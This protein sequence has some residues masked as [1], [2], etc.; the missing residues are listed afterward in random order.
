MS[1]QS[2]N[3]FT[4][5]A[6]ASSSKKTTGAAI[7]D[8]KF[9][10]S[11]V[12]A[13]RT[14]PGPLSSPTWTIKKPS[15]FISSSSGATSGTC[16]S[17]PQT[18]TAS[19]ICQAQQPTANALPRQMIHC[20]PLGSNA[21]PPMAV[22]FR[23]SSTSL[24]P[25]PKVV[26]DHIATQ[27]TKY[28]PDQA[29]LDQIEDFHAAKGRQ[30]AYEG[31]R[32]MDFPALVPNLYLL[33]DE[34]QQ[35]QASP[36]YSNIAAQNVA[37]GSKISPRSNRFST[38]SWKETS[39]KAEDWLPVSQSQEDLFRRSPGGAYRAQYNLPSNVA[40]FGGTRMMAWEYG[41]SGHISLE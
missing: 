9:T 18:A 6:A 1:F 4:P 29:K 27:Y 33:L 10:F 8:G 39:M 41:P 17:H 20:C 15:G 25:T 34:D 22:E 37:A 12:Q 40:T 38:Y 11:A 31:C 7:P 19:Y 32:H 13:A 28:H 24:R 26:K 35:K 30:P 16:N 14:Q 3:R 5:L 21:G 36:S 23:H 2:N